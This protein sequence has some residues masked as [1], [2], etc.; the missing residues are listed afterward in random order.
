MQMMVFACMM[1]VYLYYLLYTET[2][3]LNA[4]G[5][6]EAYTQ[7]L[8]KS[9]YQ[10][11]VSMSGIQS[12]NKAVVCNLAASLYCMTYQSHR[13]PL[14]SRQSTVEDDGLVVEEKD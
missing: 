13:D 14:L 7:T 3:N 5:A 11:L 4:E 8:V 2:T 6:L 12:A 10:F 1:D 9:Q